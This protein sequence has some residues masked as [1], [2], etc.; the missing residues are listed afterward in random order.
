MEAVVVLIIVVIGLVI[1]AKQGWFRLMAKSADVLQNKLDRKIAE[2][3]AEDEYTYM[4]NLGKT[5]EKWNNNSKSIANI[6]MVKAAREAALA[7][8]TTEAK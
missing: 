8:M 6:D 3:E 7:R 5:A 4:R 1:L 2:I